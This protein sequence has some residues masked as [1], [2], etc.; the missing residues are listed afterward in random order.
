[1]GINQFHYFESII[2][3]KLESKIRARIYNVNLT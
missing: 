1:M 3:L 2:M